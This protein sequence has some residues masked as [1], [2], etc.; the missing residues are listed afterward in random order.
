LAERW[1]TRISL[2]LIEPFQVGYA[3]FKLNIAWMV[4]VS[5]EGGKRSVITKHGVVGAS[6]L[7]DYDVVLDA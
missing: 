3:Q 7:S 2:W 1:S 4:T 5:W 6:Q